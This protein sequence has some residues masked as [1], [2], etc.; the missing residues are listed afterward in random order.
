MNCEDLH[1]ERIASLIAQQIARLHKIEFDG[2]FERRDQLFDILDK[3]VNLVNDDLNNNDKLI[4]KRQL[5]AE[6]EFL[7]M[8]LPRKIVAIKGDDLVFSHNDLLPR[9]I[10]YNQDNNQINFIDF[11]YAFV[12][13]RAFDI[14]DQVDW[15]W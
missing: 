11:E 7:K 1:D 12:N 6:V 5:A 13:N 2:K 8:N 14:G 4:S 3:F 15:T 10:I 9:N